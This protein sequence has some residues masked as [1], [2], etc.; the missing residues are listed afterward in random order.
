MFEPKKQCLKRRR[1]K[2]GGWSWKAASDTPLNSAPPLLPRLR[3]RRRRFRGEGTDQDAVAG[4]AE[5]ELVAEDAGGGDVA[6]GDGDVDCLE[7]VGLAVEEA[8]G[9]AAHHQ[10]GTA[11][12]AGGDQPRGVVGQLRPLPFGTFAVAPAGAD[13]SRPPEQDPPGER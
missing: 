4:G 1:G 5:E 2:R 7:L 13:P 10:G 9:V 6:G 12:V 3:L 8:D 11:V